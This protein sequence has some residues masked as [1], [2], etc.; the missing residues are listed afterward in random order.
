ML[1]PYTSADFKLLEK[2]VT[3]EDLL[4]QFAGTDFSY[5]ITRQQ[6][7]VYRTAYPERNFYIA[8]QD[9]TPFA[10][11]E[12]ILQGSGIPKLARILVGEPSL[13]GK[14]LGGKFIKSLVAESARL[15][16]TKTLELLVWDQN[17]A[18]IKCYERVGF[19]YSP[20]RHTMLAHKG[21][22]YNIHKMTYFF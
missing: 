16:S 12:I 2:W 11:G 8:Y 21:K 18:A 20:E 6:I 1:K 17:I 22:N 15:Y 19:V 14:G 9:E 10:F 3:D 13:R 5:P 7:T 4:L